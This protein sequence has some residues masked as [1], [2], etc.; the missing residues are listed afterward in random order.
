MPTVEN[1]STESRL[2]T[3]VIAAW[4]ASWY[5]AANFVLSSDT[6]L[7][8]H[9]GARG[10]FGDQFGAINALFSGLAFTGVIVTLLLQRREIKNQSASLQRQ[11]FESGF[12]QLLAL[13]SGL[14]DQLDIGGFKGRQAF[15]KFL[16]NMQIKSP[17]MDV[18][19]LLKPLDRTDIGGLSATGVLSEVLKVKLGNSSSSLIEN[20]IAKE[21][22]IGLITQYMDVDLNQHRQ[23][24]EKAYLAAHVESKDALSHYFRTLYHIL[25]YVDRSALILE[26]EKKRYAKLI[27]AQLSGLE[28][29]VL[30]YN[31]LVGAKNFG[32]QT[33]DFGFP[34]M[35]ILVKK[36]QL[37]KNLNVNVLF[38][39][40]HLDVFKKIDVK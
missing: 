19:E 36:Y 8:T 28:L 2:V 38:H 10:V 6:K 26:V 4:A 31:S 17:Q 24:I 22:G 16:K 18:F 5:Y 40:I 37:T 14:I 15:E 33:L 3:F 29:V 20:V 21:G 27:G 25:Q 32:G 34:A 7:L 35:L 23:I 1:E 11:Q 9:E 12:F 39:P 30:F 13:H